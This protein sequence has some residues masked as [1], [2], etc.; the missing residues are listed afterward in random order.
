MTMITNIIYL[1]TLETELSAP[2]IAALNSVPA[3]QVVPIL[4]SIFDKET[5]LIVKSRAYHAL[6]GINGYD[7]VGFLRDIFER[8]SVD[9]QIFNCTSLSCFQDPR[10][11]QMLCSAALKNQDPDVRYVAADSLGALGDDTAVETLESVQKHDLGVDFEGFRIAEAARSSIV[12]IK[13]RLEGV[14]R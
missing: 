14:A 9:W 10:A 1:D 7:K 11:I 3:D 12:K 6:M 8:S 13:S 2:E 4:S 5:D